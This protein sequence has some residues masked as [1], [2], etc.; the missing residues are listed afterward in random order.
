MVRHFLRLYLLIVLTL[1]A[2]SWGQERLWQMYGHEFSGG[3]GEEQPQAALLQLLESQMSSMPREQ[4]QAFV[5][6]VARDSGI[7]VELFALEDL[8]GSAMSTRLADRNVAFMNGADRRTWMLKRMD[9]AVLV[10]RYAPVEPRRSALDWALA[11]VFY[12]AIALVIMSWLW[13]LQR[14]LR[15]LEQSTGTFGNRN[16]KF[17]AVIAPRSQVHPLAEAFKRM[18]G[19]IDALIRSHKDMS[20]AMSHEIKTPLA[21]MRF[22]VEMARTAPTPQK[23]TQHLDDIDTNIAELDAFVTATLDYAILERAEVALNIAPHD[24][25]AILPAVTATVRRTSRTSI[26]MTCEVAANA[27][28]VPCDAHLMETV[29]RNLLNNA[30]RYA[31][32]RILVTCECIESHARI[33]VDDDGPGIAEA[34]RQRVFA[35]FVRLDRTDRDKT[36]FGLGLAIV[37]RVMEWHGGSA[38]VERSAMGGARFRVEW[39]LNLRTERTT[40]IKES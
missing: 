32:Q 4:H 11:F 17:D 18:A 38:A 16:W 36:N 29:L 39:P 2:V 30:T 33:C 7:D 20:N 9:D 27:T 5:R 31:R 26:E 15:Q 19:R 40:D 28:R 14:D 8:A 25:T 6:E 10:Y 24:L 21:R 1:A 34:D 22:D 35:S 37:Q 13:P 3:T 12:A 23:L